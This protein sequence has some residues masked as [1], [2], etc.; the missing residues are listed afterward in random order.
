MNI[1]VYLQK[2]ELPFVDEKTIEKIRKLDCDFVLVDAD[3]LDDYPDV[4][5]TILESGLKVSLIFS[6]LHRIKLVD[7]SNIQ[8]FINDHGVELVF[9]RIYETVGQNANEIAA[10]LNDFWKATNKPQIA[11]YCAL[12]TLNNEETVVGKVYAAIPK[13]EMDTPIL[14]QF[15]NWS[16]LDEIKRGHNKKM[17]GIYYPGGGREEFDNEMNRLKTKNIDSVF[18]FPLENLTWESPNKSKSG[19]NNAECAIAVALRRSPSLSSPEIRF[20]QV[21]ESVKI[22]KV[23]NMGSLKFGK[24]G[25]Y[26]A[27]IRNAQTEYLKGDEYDR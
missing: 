8:Q 16:H 7:T 4:F 9:V 25:T 26:W 17:L 2:D 27:L 15:V 5:N 10:A 14:C 21:G 6:L 22:D 23:I 20:L 3:R 19:G 18:V 24:I 12:T 11:I 13:E 1:G